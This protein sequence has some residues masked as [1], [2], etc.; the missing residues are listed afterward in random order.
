MDLKP[1]ATAMS[2][3]AAASPRLG[4]VT[5][6]SAYVAVEPQAF[7]AMF[8]TFPPFLSPITQLP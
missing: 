8:V 6:D 5:Y 4:G 3:L 7:C 2:P 1:L